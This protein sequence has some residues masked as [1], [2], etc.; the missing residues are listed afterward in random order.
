MPDV[1]V[2]RVTLLSDWEIRPRSF[3]NCYQ[4]LRGNDSSPA[5]A[6]QDR[7]CSSHNS[8]SPKGYSDAV[9]PMRTF[10]LLA[11]VAEMNHFSKSIKSH[12]IVST[13]LQLSKVNTMLMIEEPARSGRWW[14]LKVAEAPEFSDVVRIEG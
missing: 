2:H 1:N 6:H 14:T 8:E 10:I 4:D 12:F 5:Y 13:N 7:R 3:P 11:F 9:K